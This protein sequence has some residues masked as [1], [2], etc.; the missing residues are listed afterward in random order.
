MS[1]SGSDVSFMPAPIEAAFLGLLRAEAR[2]V[3]HVR[4]P[5]GASV[6]ALG[7]KESP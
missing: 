3:R 5:I 2:M 6:L 4:L 7:R 1:R